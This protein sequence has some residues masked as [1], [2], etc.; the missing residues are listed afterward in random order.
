LARATQI[1]STD[2]STF[3]AY[4]V[5]LDQTGNHDTARRNYEIA[6]KLSPANPVIETNI[7]MS[8]VLTGH[9]N[10][11]E[12]TLRRLV[13]RPD[14]TPQMRQNLAMIAS[15]KGNAVEAEQLA[16]EDLTA[17]QAKNNLTVL[18]QLDAD[19]AKIATPT[20]E[21]SLPT[22]ETKS[23]VIEA[24]APALASAPAVSADIETAPVVT[25]TIE[26]AATPAKP[27]T[28]YQMTPI[29]DDVAPSTPATPTPITPKATHKTE[30]APPI[31]KPATQDKAAT[32]PAQ[33]QSSMLRKSY[34]T[35][36]PISVANIAD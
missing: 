16:R 25:A 8:F 20:P 23:A 34:G 13:A 29:A 19:N 6:L 7:A 33:K 18:R 32:Q 30:I 35:Q 14:A 5:A 28:R 27:E 3:S 31:A 12:T 26:P 11:A 36:A 21:A 22:P 1:D 9:L 2:W 10:Q 15:L 4:G 24:P 17:D